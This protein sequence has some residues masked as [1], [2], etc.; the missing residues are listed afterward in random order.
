MNIEKD[1]IYARGKIYKL[2]SNSTNDVYYGSTTQQYLCQRIAGH[3]YDYKKWKEGKQHYCSSYEIIKYND[4]Q[5]ILIE[6]YPCNN[7]DELSK[8]EG[9]YVI[10]NLC[11]NSHTPGRTHNESV[12]A[13]YLK[14]EA[15]IKLYRGSKIT[16]ECGSLIARNNISTHRKQSAHKQNIEKLLSNPKL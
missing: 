9:Y 13:Y 12:K 16:C 1:N 11:I 4:V 2:I 14:N 8:R 10:N 3:K 7:K 15:R 6:N 5:I